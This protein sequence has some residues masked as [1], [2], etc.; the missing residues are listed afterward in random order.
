MGDDLHPLT[1]PKIL[2]I[3]LRSQSNSKHHFVKMKYSI[4]FLFLFLFKS[5]AAQVSPESLRE[6]IFSDDCTKEISAEV[7]KDLKGFYNSL[8]YNAQWISSTKNRQEIL[9]ILKSAADNG[10]EP[11]NYR[12]DIASDLS[13]DNISFK[14]LNDSLA[15]E[16]KITETTIRFFRDLV[17]GSSPQLSYSGINYKPSCVD[18]PYFLAFYTA[19]HSLWD[20]V[21]HFNSFTPASKSILPKIKWYT[22]V[23]NDVGFKEDPVSSTKTFINNK[24]L[25]KKLYYLGIIDTLDIELSE[26]QVEEK[27]KESQRQFNLL[28]D[29]I[30]RA[31][32]LQELNIPLEA[33]LKELKLSLN[34]YRWLNCLTTID[35]VIVVNIPAADLK[36]Y[37]DRKILL[38][39]RMVVGKPTTP[40]PTLSSI[41]NEVILYPY[42][43]VPYSIATKEL[44]PS[45]QR[46]PG[47]L[48]ANNFQVLNAQG[49]IVD[50]YSV[51]W[52]ALSATNFPYTIR[53]STGCDNALGLLKLN[54]YS[55]SGVYLHDTPNKSSFLLNKR[56]FSHGCMRMECPFDMGLLLLKNNRL[57]ID[58]LKEDLRNKKPVI[59]PADQPMP[60]IVWYNPCGFDET[61][62]VVFFED[63]YKK[64]NRSGKQP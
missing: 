3:S 17:Y 10:L 62:R 18:I 9:Q 33:R 48:T 4:A 49:K 60:V 8:S 40:T 58:T 41:V 27:V 12:I 11:G 52:S 26:K 37:H 43:F 63:V 42:W 38:Q 21:D 22:K 36:V 46:N 13:I 7:R 55:P 2:I 15:A 24:A 61:G 1:G 44:L 29:G 16:I 31:T 51:N 30:L 54:F 56:Y 34:Y 28:A 57:A 47:Y 59:I 5:T 39:M 23:I 25:I 14:T 53:Q 32:V 20:L 50:P 45:I 19:G 64:F 35:S 6:F